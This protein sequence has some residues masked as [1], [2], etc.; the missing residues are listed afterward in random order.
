MN[1]KETIKRIL[2][3]DPKGLEQVY[4]KNRKMI[5]RLVL[6]NSGTLEQADDLLQDSIIIFYRKLTE[7]NLILSC[8][9]ST[10][11][12]SVAWNCW[13]KELKRMKRFSNEEVEISSDDESIFM[14]RDEEMAIIRDAVDKLSVS[15]QK[16]I[17]LHL[18]GASISDITKACS[19]KT[20]DVSKTALY[21]AKLQLKAIV[22]DLYDEEDVK[23]L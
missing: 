23:T 10:Y 4:S 1:D 8:K 14:E 18:D 17:N 3:N 5:T 20:N 9:I 15:S 12:Y 11:L 19:Y 21:K 6:K 7:Q 2:A 13:R 22:L 16:L